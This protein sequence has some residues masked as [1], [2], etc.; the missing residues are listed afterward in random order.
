DILPNLPPFIDESLLIDVEPFTSRSTSNSILRDQLEKSR[1]KSFV[2][3]QQQQPKTINPRIPLDVD[4]LAVSLRAKFDEMMKPIIYKGVKSVE[5]SASL[6]NL[7]LPS[8]VDNPLI[9]PNLK[10]HLNKPPTQ[11]ELP[12]DNFA[13]LPDQSK[14]TQS[15]LKPLIPNSELNGHNVLY[16]NLNNSIVQE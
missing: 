5:S 11:S 14:P 10:T 13:V 6:E 15:P 8:K 12:F 2:E 9:Q 7:N 3:V 1:E 4:Q 16:S